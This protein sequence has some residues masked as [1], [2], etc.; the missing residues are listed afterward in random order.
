MIDMNVTKKLLTAQGSQTLTISLHINE[1]DFS[2]FFGQ[3]GTGKT[4]T[5][6]M[7]A[8]LVKPDSGTICV[9]NTIWFDFDSNINLP[10]QKRNIGFV[11]QDYA[12]FPSM[13]VL[14]NIEYAIGNDRPKVDNIIE[15]IGLKPFANTYPDQLSGGQRQRV[16]LARTLVRSPKILLLDEPLSALDNEMRSALQDELCKMHDFFRLTSIIVTHDISE[17][18]RIARSVAVFNDFKISRQGTPEEI[19]GHHLSTNFRVVGTII[20]I[21]QSDVA[22]VVTVQVGVNQTKVVIDIEETAKYRRGQTVIVA[23]KAFTPVLLP[24]A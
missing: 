10:T 2:A 1:G 22:S 24:I 3:S 9:N 21:K 12:L 18:Y 13:T 15:L 17:I 14:K 6:R 4:T 8:G 19:F 5:L 16:A 23:A 7:L 20:E 11:F